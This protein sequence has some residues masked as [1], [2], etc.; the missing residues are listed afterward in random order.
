MEVLRVAHGRTADG[1]SEGC[2]PGPGALTPGPGEH[3]HPL[4]PHL[5][6]L[7]MGWMEQCWARRPALVLLPV[8]KAPESPVPS[9]LHLTPPACGSTRTTGQSREDY[10]EG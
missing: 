2:S 6:A 7:P 9:P 1:D 5:P 8:T 3:L 4:Q 10:G